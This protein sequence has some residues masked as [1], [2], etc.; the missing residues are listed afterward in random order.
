[1]LRP[2]CPAPAP[3][4]P[5]PE[6]GYVRMGVEEDRALLTALFAGL[7]PEDRRLRFFGGGEPSD[8]ADHWLDVSSSGGLGI[9]AVTTSAAGAES[10]VG[11]ACL[12]PR[13]DGTADFA[14]SVALAARGGLGT[15]LLEILRARAQEA[16]IEALRGDVLVRN[17]AMNRILRRMGG[18]TIDREDSSCVSVLVAT[19][20]GA[21]PWP[22]VEGSSPRVLIESR[23][24]R[25]RGEEELRSHGY[26]VAICPG[27]VSRPAGDPCPLV[28]GGLCRLVDGAD[29]VVHDLAPG[30]SANAAVCSHLPQDDR[31]KVLT[32]RIDRALGP[33]DVVKTVERSQW[34]E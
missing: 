11:E 24:G 2:P 12:V 21:P 20:L 31:V 27:P 25:W 23:H 9:I 22:E 16:G 3:R 5:L 10:C 29:V 15:T 26:Q 34:R 6:G 18:V 33:A 8:Q 13:G 28:V 4:V 1:M 17:R 32:P 30:I 14:M 7:P 19:A